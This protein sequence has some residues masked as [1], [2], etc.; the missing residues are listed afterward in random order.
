MRATVSL[1]LFI[2]F[3]PSQAA[4]WKSPLFH[5]EAS[6]PD[7]AGW[8]RDET[9]VPG[10]TVLVA[11]RNPLKQAVFGI[12]IVEKI[13]AAG[14]D[15]Q[16]IRQELE[17]RLKK[18]SYEFAGHST[19]NVGG[20]EWVQYNVRTGSDRQQMA[21]VVRFASAGG[22]VFGI[23]LLRGG[24][25]DATQ[26]V[27]LQQ[28]GASFRI[29]PAT[30]AAVSATGTQMQKT[31]VPRPVGPG[32]ESRTKPLPPAADDKS[33]TPDNPN[34]PLLWYAG[35]GIIGLLVLLKIIGGSKQVGKP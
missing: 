31:S 11:M 7:S 4:Q 27:E 29:M 1:L 8:V 9:Q 20:I 12:N 16:A 21:G 19:V 30:T 35:A 17:T 6:L 26:D 13:S 33:Q 24:G 23:T 14:I 22:Y 34:R 18:F 15:S 2:L 32:G 5:C 10:I 3:A 25:Q 28:A